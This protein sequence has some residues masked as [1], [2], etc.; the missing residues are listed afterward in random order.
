MPQYLKLVTLRAVKLLFHPLHPSCSPFGEQ[1]LLAGTGKGTPGYQGS[2]PGS[3][4]KHWSALD[5]SLDP[6]CHRFHS[7]E[8]LSY[9][10]HIKGI[11]QHGLDRQTLLRTDPPRSVL[12]ASSANQSRAQISLLLPSW[13]TTA[14]DQTGDGQLDPSIGAHPWPQTDSTAQA[15]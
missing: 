4:H 11:L 2:C 14:A 9:S 10:D 1:N 3:V 5:K 6:S 8:R 7:H 12:R 13:L 15:L